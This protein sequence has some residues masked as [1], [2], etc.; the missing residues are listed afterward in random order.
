MKKITVQSKISY[1][2]FILLI[3]LCVVLCAGVI[4]ILFF[5]DFASSRTKND[6]WELISLIIFFFPIFL[7]S[8]L[9]KEVYL[10]EILVFDDYIELIYKK[11]NKVKM[12]KKI[13]K[14]DIKSFSINAELIVQNVGKS[15]ICI[16]T[17]LTSIKLKNDKDV[18]FNQDSA[19]KLFGCPY[20]YILDVLSACKDIPNFS[21]KLHGNNEFARAD[22]DY[23]NRFGRRMPFWISFKYTLKKTPLIAKILLGICLLS[24]MISMGI[25]VFMNLPSMPLSDNEKEYMN[26]Y[27][28]AY[29][30]R[31]EKNEYN[32]A[33]VELEQAK[34]F[35]SDN[36]ELYR[37][38]AYNYE[39]LK[40]YENASKVARE[41]LKYIK[42]K[43][44]A[45]KKF[46]NFKFDTKEDIYL[47]SIIAKS[48]RKLKHYSNAIDAYSYIIKKSHYTY[49]D[50]HFW[51]GYCY[52]YNGE[53]NL[54]HED[55]LKHREIILKY[56]ED[57]RE[58]E[59]KDQYPRYNNDDL[60]N[61][62][63]WIEATK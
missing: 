39:D 18:Y 45:Y 1:F 61:V 21:Y 51:R 38:L 41:G 19:D 13:L 12:T 17:F 8:L 31:V 16:C 36:P 5:C 52:Y 59:Y 56:F 54:A 35:V 3:I 50:S 28:R 63:K 10:G 20:Q 29:D 55:F 34:K 60:V 4:Y 9:S 44:T 11:Q 62:D 26:Y 14:S 53:I 47:Y 30:L 33:I 27:N 6:G 32:R 43:N 49:D 37:E 15:S 7:K 25:L 40:D 46:H 22:I 23:F 48:E 57:Q 24:V 2:Q 58:S 42:N